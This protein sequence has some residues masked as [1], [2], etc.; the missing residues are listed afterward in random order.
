MFLGNLGESLAT[1]GLQVLNL[2][3]EKVHPPPFTTATFCRDSYRHFAGW[4]CG[5]L[6]LIEYFVDGHFPKVLSDCRENGKPSSK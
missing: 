3:M 6:C 4:S 1:I 5:D 2:F